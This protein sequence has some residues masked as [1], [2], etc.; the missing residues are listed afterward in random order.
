MITLKGKLEFISFWNPIRLISEDSEVDLRTDYFRVLTNLNG[1]K[2]SMSGKMN[3]I[4]IFA[5]ESSDRLMRYENKGETIL[6]ILEE[7]GPK[8]GMTNLGAYVPDILQRLNGMMVIV[9]FDDESINIYHDETEKVYELNYTH[10]NSCI[11]PDDK[12]HEICKIGTDDCCIF[13]TVGGNGF[14][15]EKFNSG[16]AGTLLDRYSK[17]KMNAKR[18]GNCKIVGRIEG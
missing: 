1:K 14:S 7:V 18:I 9:E 16:M 4:K 15:C 2:A 10:N 12:T 3:D 11:I 17:G 5:D 8:W 13:L 6:M